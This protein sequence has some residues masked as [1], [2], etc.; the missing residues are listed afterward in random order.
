MTSYEFTEEQLC[1][2][3]PVH[4]AEGPRGLYEWFHGSKPDSVEAVED[5]A[6]AFYS[7]FNRNVYPRY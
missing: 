4:D 5:I 7:Q 6:I 3:R 1:E 2:M